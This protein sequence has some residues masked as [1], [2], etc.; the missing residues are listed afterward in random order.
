MPGGL[1]DCTGALRIFQ[2]ETPPKIGTPNLDDLVPLCPNC[3]TIVHLESP[4]LTIN[5][6]KEII[7]EQKK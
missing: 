6:L 1:P 4:P 3:H 2:T 7:K 5:R